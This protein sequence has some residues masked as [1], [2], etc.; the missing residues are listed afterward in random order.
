MP[1]LPDA[2]T[3]TVD[4]EHSLQIQERIKERWMPGQNNE[5]HI[6]GYDKEYH[7]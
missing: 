1:P 6:R 4:V 2:W 5:R 7:L 3:R